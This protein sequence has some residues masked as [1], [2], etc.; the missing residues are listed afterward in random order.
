MKTKIPYKI[1]SLFSGCF[2]LLISLS[3][4]LNGCKKTTNFN[5][6]ILITGTETQPTTRFTI[7]GASSMG[8]TVTATDKVYR[9]TKVT[10]Q[11]QPQLMEAYNK[12]NSR[13]YQVPPEGSY[14]LTDGEVTIKNGDYRSTQAKLSIVSTEN[15]KEG[16]TY[17]LPVSITQTDGDMMVLEESRTDYIVINRVLTTKAVN[18]SE[19]TYF[20][21]PTFLTSPDVAA[22]SALTMEC[23]VFVNSFQS[24]SPFIASVMGIE[25]N[26]LLRFGDVSCEKNQ[27]QLASGTIGGKQFPMTTATRFST[28]Q[29]YHIAVVYNGSTLTIYINGKQETYATTSGGNANFNDRYMGGFHIGFSERG[30]M[31]DG[32]ISEARL[33][34]KAL[35]P[36]QLQE[37]V[38]FV[39]PTSVGLLAYW[40]FNGE[41]QDEKVLDLTGHGHDAVASGSI[42]WIDGMKCPF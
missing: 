10:L 24:Y 11:V 27:L 19:S 18:L 29:W 3:V 17:C 16:V 40:R 9:D 35:T 33:W 12:A 39:N 7:D 36:N 42:K 5:D 34:N 41:S 26:F 1:L 21:I 37:G 22:L 38:C 6:V 13:S 8:L 32:Y 23:K 31:L 25:E 14:T 30:R 15:F 28:G 20:T 4:L 2:V